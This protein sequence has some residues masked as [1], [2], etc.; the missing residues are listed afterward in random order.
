MPRS[1][2]WVRRLASVVAALVLAVP[3]LAGTTGKLTR[4]DRR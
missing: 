1:R 2:S 3:A 4:T